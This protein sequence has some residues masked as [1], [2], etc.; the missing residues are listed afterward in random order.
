MGIAWLKKNL[1]IVIKAG[2]ESF[3]F[4]ESHDNNNFE[5]NNRSFSSR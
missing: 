4:S 2:A 3:L 5:K 1:L